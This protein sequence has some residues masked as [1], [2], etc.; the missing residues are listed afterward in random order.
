VIG[1]QMIIRPPLKSECHLN[2]SELSFIKREN[3]E[4]KTTR[5]TAQI[6]PHNPAIRARTTTQKE[7]PGQQHK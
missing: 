7:P 2:Y 4:D 3:K 5:T 6:R 1:I